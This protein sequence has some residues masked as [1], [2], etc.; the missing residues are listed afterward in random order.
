MKE[1]SVTKS[2]L[3]INLGSNITRAL[4][5]VLWGGFLERFWEN[6]ASTSEKQCI[7]K[8]LGL[9]ILTQ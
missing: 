5:Q 9:F 6:K 7:G 4:K 2:K 1:L 3:L 8:I